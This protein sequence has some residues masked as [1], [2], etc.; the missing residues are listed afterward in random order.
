M[1]NYN[2]DELLSMEPV[3]LMN[4]FEEDFQRDVPEVI[5]TVDELKRAGRALGALA[6]DY[7]YLAQLSAYAKIDVREKKRNSSKDKD[8]IED[9]ID[10]K[11]VIDAFLSSTDMRY[12]AVSRMLTTKQQINEELKMTDGLAGGSQYNA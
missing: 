10:R 9:A 3:K 12:K 2:V 1:R 8:A 5:E 7:S 11:A 4:L 6:A